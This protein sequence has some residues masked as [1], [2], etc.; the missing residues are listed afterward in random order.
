MAKLDKQVIPLKLLGY[1]GKFDSK[2]APPGTLSNAENVQAFRRTSEGGVELRKRYGFTEV[3]G[4]KSIA[5]GGSI[6]ACQTGAAY[7]DELVLCDG[8]KLYSR[9]DTL[10]KWALK[11]KAQ[12][13]AADTFIVGGNESQAFET[14]GDAAPITVDVAYLG[15]FACHVASGSDLLLDTPVRIH[16]RDVTT[17]VIVGTFTLGQRYRAK[18]VACGTAFFVFC[19]KQ[20]T[21]GTGTTITVHKIEVATPASIAASVDVTTDVEPTN[22]NG[23]FDV[24]ADTASGKIWVA[25]NS[26]T[27]VGI[28]SWIA[29]TNVAG[30]SSVYTT[31]NAGVACGFL[32]WD[33]SNSRGYVGIV[34]DTGTTY[35]VRIVEFNTASGVETADTFIEGY[36]A[37]PLRYVWGITGYRTAAGVLNAFWSLYDGT[38]TSP[39]YIIRE[40]KGY[41]GGTVFTVMK[42]IQL[43]GR[44]FKVGAKWYF[45]ASYDA[46]SE[47]IA[48]RT[49]LIEIEENCTGAVD[50]QIA[51]AGLL[52]ETDA[53]GNITSPSCL[54][55]APAIT[56]TRILTAAP[57]VLARPAPTARAS[58]IHYSNTAVFLD[59]TGAGLGKPVQF[60]DVLH[61]PAAAH[62]EYDGKD[63]VESGFYC[64]PE[65]PFELS[66]SSGSFGQSLEADSTYQYCITFA[67]M[68]AKGRLHRSTPSPVGTLVTPDAGT[69]AFPQGTGYLRTLRITDTHTKFTH[70][71]LVSNCRIELWRTE[72]NLDVFYLCQWLENEALDDYVGQFVDDM[73]DATLVNN[74]IL[75][76]QSEELDNQ[77]P[78]AVKVLHPFQNRLV[79]LTGDGSSWFTKEGAEGFGS[80][81]SDEFR[82]TLGT[83][84]GRPTTIGSVDTSLVIFK[85]KRAYFTQGAGPDDKGA[86]P[87]FPQPQALEIELGVVNATG[88]IDVPTGI[89]CETAVGRFTLTRAL[90]FEAVEGTEDRSLTVVGGV[91][92]DSRSM[93]VLVT[94]GALLIRDWQLNQWFAWSKS[95]NGLA[96]VAICVSRGALHVFQSDGTVLR[97]VSGQYFDATSTAINE[98]VEFMF[99]RLE[100]LRLYQCRLVG[101][102]MGSTTL[103]ETVA[104]NGNESTAASKTKAVTTADADDLNVIPNTGRA[105]SVK[106]KLQETSTT[107]GF[108]LS[109]VGLEVGQKAGLKKVGTGRNFT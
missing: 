10:A 41:S 89:L 93:T 8:A 65:R 3:T 35:D 102:I 16:V 73:P 1:D 72:A 39:T 15:G 88:A 7:N 75:Y 68:D 18:V 104:Y 12:S 13:I 99:V 58:T 19:W 4:G 43:T 27:G 69:E 21:A 106:F 61:I 31:R 80:E 17:G 108:R 91:G 37:D 23:I 71:E 59:F 100:N 67:R 33:F 87:P 96:G 98:I 62:R 38:P 60:N 48:P 66:Y 49:L 70:N 6:A 55:S 92:L 30:V 32:N 63:V 57:T 105:A 79:A 52:F 24:M 14:G 90:T 97:E 74:E 20:P 107:E 36:G 22:D 42:G 51:V 101:Q 86:G 78:P 54:T 83:D 28:M 76:T 56:A 45:Q 46:A 103:T 11:G 95:A 77:K 53:F 84:G 50:G 9:S 26:T 40:V 109:M 29:A 44:A 85:R 64:D 81:W 34:D 94:G 25:W 82:I 2:V 47:G 5:S